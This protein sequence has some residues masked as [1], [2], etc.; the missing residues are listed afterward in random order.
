MEQEIQQQQQEQVGPPDILQQLQD[1]MLRLQ[2]LEH[3][4]YQEK[5]QLLRAI[6]QQMDCN[7]QD[8]QG[9]FQDFLL[10]ERLLLDLAPG[11]ENHPSF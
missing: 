1:R 10:L 5:Q 2:Q 4:S 6:L 11:N 9:I 7:R 3:E 8:L